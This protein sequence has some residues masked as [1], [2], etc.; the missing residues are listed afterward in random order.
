[1][2]AILEVVIWVYFFVYPSF[3]FAIMSLF[4]DDGIGLPKSI[5]VN[6][7]I[8]IF[9]PWIILYVIIKKIIS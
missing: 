5:L 9:W 3:L 7:I 6:I 1:M 8:S 4:P 2:E